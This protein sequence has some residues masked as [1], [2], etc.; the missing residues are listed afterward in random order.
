MDMAHVCRNFWPLYCC[1]YRT[2]VPVCPVHIPQRHAPKLDQQTMS[3]CGMRIGHVNNAV[4][5]DVL[6]FND[7]AQSV[8]V[9]VDA[10]PPWPDLLPGRLRGISPKMPSGKLGLSVQVGGGRLNRGVTGQNVRVGR[11]GM[12]GGDWRLKGGMR[13]GKQTE[14]EEE[15]GGGW[16]WGD[17]HA[18]PQNARA[19]VPK[20]EGD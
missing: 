13:E 2:C 11:G 7:A 1:V 16:C 5:D 4:R 18:R 12:W 10:C 17:S 3:G 15:R 14:R 9:N 8:I 6:N 19:Q 20:K